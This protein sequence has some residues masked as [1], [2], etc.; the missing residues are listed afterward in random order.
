[1][2]ILDLHV[3]VALFCISARSPPVVSFLV[4]SLDRPTMRIA[5]ILDRN[6]QLNHNLYAALLFSGRART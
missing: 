5:D 2:F 4:I 6:K 3:A 1:M